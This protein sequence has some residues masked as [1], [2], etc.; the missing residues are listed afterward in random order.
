MKPL[1]IT[2]PNAEAVA[3]VAP[4]L[5]V[6]A[7]TGGD[8]ALKLY[9]QLAAIAPTLVIDYG[10]KSWQQLSRQLGDI[11]GHKADAERAI[12]QFEQRVQAV[13]QAITLPP[14]PVSALVYYEDG[15]GANI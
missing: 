4:D 9:D 2:E 7:A 6:I 14:Q 1:Y 10:D 12:A 15:R 5:I 8:S 3:A 11:T 13:K